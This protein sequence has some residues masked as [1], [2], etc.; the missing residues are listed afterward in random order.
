MI[1]TQD[2]IDYGEPYVTAYYSGST[3]GGNWY[4]GSLDSNMQI[5]VSQSF[6][7]RSKKDL[8]VNVTDIVQTWYSS[9]KNATG[10]GVT[11]TTMSNDGFIVK[12]EDVY[13]I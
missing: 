6:K 4:T 3:G 5:E 12:W 8:D 1:L 2:V 13:R 11:F 9:S 10:A 7:Q